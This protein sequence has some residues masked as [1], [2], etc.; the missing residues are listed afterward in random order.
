MVRDQVGRAWLA[1][2]TPVFR[3]AEG[4][5]GMRSPVAGAAP[6]WPRRVGRTGR[7]G[8]A[9]D[10]SRPQQARPAVYRPQLPAHV[11][12][13]R[14]VRR[15]PGPLRDPPIRVDEARH[16][17]PA[18]QGI[19]HSRQS[20]V[21]APLTG[22]LKAPE[23]WRQGQI[24]TRWPLPGN[25]HLATCA[26]NGNGGP[27]FPGQPG[28]KATGAIDLCPAELIGSNFQSPKDRGPPGKVPP[29]GPGRS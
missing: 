18:T 1:D 8:G 6:T 16:F 28:G 12:T 15:K 2:C 27:R 13:A 17:R 4:W 21:C 3:A 22:G 14:P 26:S 11:T 7:G 29:T 9:D 19:R 10:N 24:S 23:R 5:S 25:R 20:N